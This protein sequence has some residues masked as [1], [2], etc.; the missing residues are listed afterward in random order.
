MV[1]IAYFTELFLQICDYAQKRRIWCENCK[2]AFVANFHCHFCSRRKAAKFFHPVR[3]NQKKGGY[4]GIFREAG[5]DT[6]TYFREITDLEFQ[7]HKNVK[8]MYF[9]HTRTSWDKFMF[10]GMPNSNFKI[11]L[12][13]FGCAEKYTEQSTHYA[14]WMRRWVFK[15]STR[16][17]DLLNSLPFTF[18]AYHNSVFLPHM[19]SETTRFCTCVI[20]FCALVWLF[21]SVNVDVPLQSFCS[22][23]W[24]PALFTVMCLLSTVGEKMLGKIFFVIEENS[25]QLH[26]FGFSVEC[27][28]MWSL[29]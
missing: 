21:S 23:E 24:A 8:K 13:L 6:G 5:E 19:L 27:V 29:R 22:V 9:P 4:R 10:N 14:V 20:T 18:T 15:W 16:P 2:Y 12:S 1:Y 25:H 26:W 11:G 3:Y 7:N 28:L 17:N